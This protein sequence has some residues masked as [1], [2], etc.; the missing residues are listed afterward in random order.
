[1]VMAVRAKSPLSRARLAFN[2]AN[3]VELV[4]FRLSYLYSAFTPLLTGAS[5]GLHN[6]PGSRCR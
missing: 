2:L 1:M 5:L 3:D 6:R 4:R